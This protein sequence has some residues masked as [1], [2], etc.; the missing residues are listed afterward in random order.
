M[1][2]VLI[3]PTTLELVTLPEA[4][5]HVRV[6]NTDDDP[7][8]TA[9]LLTAIGMAE[10]KLGRILLDSTWALWLDCW[11]MSYVIAIPGGQLISVTSITYF[12]ADNNPLTFSSA[13]Y[14][15][16][17]IGEE[18]EGR[19]LLNDGE[20]WPSETIRAA[21]GIKIQFRAGYQSAAA[22]RSEFKSLA[23]LL[24]GEL[25]EHREV[26]VDAVRQS[27]GK[28]VE[29]LASKRLWKF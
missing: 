14:T 3:T 4:K 13:N 23:M 10:E 29:A 28:S 5:L 2:K 17:G 21:D 18:H 27:T 19:I 25:Y 22:V 1:R 24:L 26:T 7:D 8:V 9:K 15:V 20:S 11:P 16:L 6:D 12:E